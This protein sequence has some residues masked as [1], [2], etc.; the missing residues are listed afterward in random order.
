MHQYRNEAKP[1]VRWV[2][3]KRSSLPYLAKYIPFTIKR[4]VEPFVGGGALFFSLNFK[5]A[6]IN[7][8]NYDLILTYKTI[9]SSPNEL[10]SLLKTFKNDEETYLQIRSWD[11]KEDFVNIDPI[12]RAARFLYLLCYGFNGLYRVSSKGYFNVP[13][14]GVYT[15]K[16]GTPCYKNFDYDVIVACSHYLS[17]NKVDIMQGDYLNTLDYIKK[18]DFVYLDPPYF[19]VKDNSFVQYQENLNS[20]NKPKHQNFHEKLHDFCVEIDK[21]GAYFMQSNSIC[22]DIMSLYTDFNISTVKAVRKVSAKASLR[23]SV[24]DIIITNYENPDDLMLQY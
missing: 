4:Y 20:C 14:G 9:Q 6:L 10:I 11:R 12:Q 2:G 8:L 3:G 24:K 17:Q 22:P 19:P 23:G 16:D 15:K 5:E 18:G 13:Y 21:K 7:D 1:F